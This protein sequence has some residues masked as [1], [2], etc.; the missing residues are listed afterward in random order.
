M[1][2]ASRAR[3]GGTTRA[4]RSRPAQTGDDHRP[5]S[6]LSP[7]GLVVP[8]R[9]RSEAGG[10]AIMDFYELLDRIVDLLRSRGRVTYGAL[11]LQFGLTEEQLTVVK[12]ELL[13]AQQ[14]ARD[15]EGRVLAWGVDAAITPAPVPAASHAQWPPTLPDVAPLPGV[16]FSSERRP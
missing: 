8:D 13:Y 6:C 10:G 7:D 16:P 3:A 15:E 2:L 11:K 14:L 5:G 4:R 12:D 9:S 1:R